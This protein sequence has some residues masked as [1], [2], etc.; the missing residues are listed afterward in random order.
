MT[1]DDEDS[2]DSECSGTLNTLASSI[3][4]SGP[5]GAQPNEPVV[6]KGVAAG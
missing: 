5:E 2:E 4:G 1:Y 3:C 6:F